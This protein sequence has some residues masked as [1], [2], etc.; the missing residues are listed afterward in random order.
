MIANKESVKANNTVIFKCA[1][2]FTR[3]EYFD[4]AVYFF[5]EAVFMD[6][7]QSKAAVFSTVHFDISLQESVFMDQHQSKAAVFFHG[8]F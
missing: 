6:Q 2:G 8:A 4:L 7:H 1:C 3:Q 5:Q